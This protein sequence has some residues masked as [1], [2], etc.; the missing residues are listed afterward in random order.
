MVQKSLER[1]ERGSIGAQAYGGVAIKNIKNVVIKEH[2]YRDEP[3]YQSAQN[4]NEAY[5]DSNI[6][7]I[8][9]RTGQQETYRLRAGSKGNNST[10]ISSISPENRSSLQV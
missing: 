10:V 6:V 9:T 4:V 8:E 7:N 2:Q 5:T 3:Q 1:G